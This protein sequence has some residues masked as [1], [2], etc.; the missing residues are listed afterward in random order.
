VYEFTTASPQLVSQFGD[1]P[2]IGDFLPGHIV[3]G[4]V[5]QTSWLQAERQSWEQETHPNE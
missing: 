2:C 3:T 5:E 4:T 1:F